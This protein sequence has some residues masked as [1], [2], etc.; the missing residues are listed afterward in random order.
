[1]YRLPTL[2]SGMNSLISLVAIGLRRSAGITLPGKGSPVIGS[3]MVPPPEK[4]PIR[5]AA[6]ITAMF[7]VVP[8]V[9]RNPS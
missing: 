6:D 7:W 9:L 5:S 3:T 1:M 8:R 4:S 2:G